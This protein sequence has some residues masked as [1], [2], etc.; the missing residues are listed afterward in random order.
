MNTLKLVVIT[1][2]DW[3]GLYSNDLIVD[4]GH[5][6][7]INVIASIT[8]KVNS[9]VDEL[10]EKDK[11]FNGLV[12]IFYEIDQEYMEDLGELPRTFE[13]LDMRKLEEIKSVY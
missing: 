2:K 5:N 9:M 11:Q 10:F 6:L 7:G 12:T 3:Q 1:A 4:E 13:E 8:D